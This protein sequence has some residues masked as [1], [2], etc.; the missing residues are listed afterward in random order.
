MHVYGYSFM[1]FLLDI[2]TVRFCLLAFER[3][4][5]GSIVSALIND[6]V[7]VAS[8]VYPLSSKN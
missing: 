7:S 1:K 8:K 4:T 5:E 2:P 6:I 3:F